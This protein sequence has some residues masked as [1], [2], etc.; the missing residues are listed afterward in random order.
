MGLSQ[1]LHFTFLITLV[2]TLGMCIGVYSCSELLARGLTELEFGNLMVL[3]HVEGL[4]IAAELR[5]FVFPLVTLLPCRWV[6]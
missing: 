4:T 1:Y 3:M 5:A 2:I 6:V